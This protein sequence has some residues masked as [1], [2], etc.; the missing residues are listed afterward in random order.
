[1]PD[2]AGDPLA[3]L[4]RLIGQQN[5][6]TPFALGGGSAHAGP[7]ATERGW[8]ATSS[9]TSAP[10]G[11]SSEAPHWPSHQPA[12]EDQHYGSGPYDPRHESYASSAGDSYNGYSNGYSQPYGDARLSGQHYADSP[13]P[14][15]RYGGE[16]FASDPRYDQS[17]YA[18]QGYAEPYSHSQYGPSGYE[19]GAARSYSDSGYADPGYGG[20]DYA[21]PRYAEPNPGFQPYG[22]QSYGSADGYAQHMGAPGYSAYGTHDGAAPQAHG[23]HGYGHAYG[24]PPLPGAMPHAAEDHVPAKR[25][26]SMVTVL[27]VL[28]LAVVGTAAAFGYR[29]VFVGAGAPV[30][31][32]VIKADTQPSKVVPAADP[33]SKPIQDRVGVRTE[34]IVPRQE[35]PVQ[36]AAPGQPRVIA[37]FLAGQNPQAFPPA[38]AN[39][40]PGGGPGA[41]QSATSQPASAEPKRVRTVPIKPQQQGAEAPGPRSSRAAEPE[42]NVAESNAPMAL[43]PTGSLPV[44]QRPAAR[45]A[46][47]ALTPNEA[48]ASGSP[49]PTPLPASTGPAASRGAVVGPYAV[50]VTSQRSESDAQASY[51]SLQ[52]QFPAVLGNR[53]PVI[54]RADLGERGT[55]YRA[56]IPFATQS[57]AT[58]FCSSLKAAGGQ[59]VVAKN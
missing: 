26:G 23:S 14:D 31:P 17:G 57:E 8:T 2:A 21:D 51:R 25:R 30:P 56:Q 33:T 7:A 12:P 41:S 1:M 22:A 38:S 16:Q 13:Y 47:A 9:Y 59:C 50:Q 40:A 35:E 39:I 43:S 46:H 28:A 36:Q 10:G 52:Q 55:Y 37:P 15:Q 48:P 54:R 18:A 44:T 27:A 3:E 53:Q 20:Q 24:A 29:A 6:S 11:G 19:S 45:Q 4:A 34:K 49:F 5:E 32:P 58:E 42:A